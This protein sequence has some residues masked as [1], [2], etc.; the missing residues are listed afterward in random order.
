MTLREFE[1]RLQLCNP[2]LHVKTYGASKAG[3][4]LGSRYICRIGPGEIMPYNQFVMETGQNDSFMSDFN[5]KGY[6]QFRRIV[7][8]GRAEAARVLY[9][10]R[11]IS[12]SDVATLS[13]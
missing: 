7:E 1:R 5:P 10:Q 6:Y 11:L 3:I 9:T 2:K 13:K 12:L 4:H 8:R